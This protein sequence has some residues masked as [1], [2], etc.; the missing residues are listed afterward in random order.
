MQGRAGTAV[1]LTPASP[2]PIHFVEFQDFHTPRFI[3][4]VDTEEE[5]DWSAPFSRDQHGTSHIG[6]IARFQALCDAHDVRPAYLVDYPIA[7]DDHAVAL[8]GGYARGGRADIG[9]QLHPW[10]NPPF[11]EEP[12]VTNS[13]ACNLKPELERAKLT[14]L[15]NFIS[16]RFGLRPQIY[17][18]GRYGA[19]ANSRK[20]LAELGMTIDSSVRSFFDYSAQ[21]GPNYAD[22]PLD[23]YWIERGRLIELPL[24][25]IFSGALR[26]G[27][28]RLFSR[29]FETVGSRGLLARTGML[30]RIALTPEG[31]PVEKALKAI[32]IAL[33]KRVPILNFSFH[34]PSLAVGHTPYVRSESDLE[35]FYS[36]WNR[37][38]EHLGAHGVKPTHVDEIRAAAGISA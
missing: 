17:R 27:G 31:I 29:A 7:A 9:V 12:D 22:C 8:L 25:T 3:V 19:G 6:S 20:I 11:D 32:D 13:F 35:S 26:A 10:V 4:T 15:Y 1:D 30:E 28:R 2:E 38:F 14:G 18:A 33:Q 5:F 36:W 16:E 37:V 24:T 21:G 34:S 23:P